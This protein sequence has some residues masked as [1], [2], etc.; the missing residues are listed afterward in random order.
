MDFFAPATCFK[1]NTCLC[2]NNPS[3]V[4]FINPVSI[5]T[6]L[7]FIFVGIYLL[8]KKTDIDFS[9]FLGIMNIAMG[10]VTIYLHMHLNFLGDV[11][12]FS[13]VIIFLVLPELYLMFHKKKLHLYSTIA[14]LFLTL[15]TFLTIYN[16]LRKYLAGIV[17]LIII[18]INIVV[19]RNLLKMRMIFLMLFFGIFI[20]ALDDSHLIACN[21]TSIFQLH[22]LFH[23]VMAMVSLRAYEYYVKIIPN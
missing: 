7:A 13:M 19:R 15:I 12:D 17:L 10:I 21:P 22:A 14:L 23:I 4:G 16:D 6:S 3:L 1:E 2:E 5:V 18:F 11:L 9:R 8:S 20:W